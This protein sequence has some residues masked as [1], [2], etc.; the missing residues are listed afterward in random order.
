MSYEGTITTGIPQG[1]VLGPLLFNIFINDLPLSITSTDVTCDL[2]ADDCSLITAAT[3]MNCINIKLQDSLTEILAWCTD[4]QMVL[5]PEKTKCMVVTTRQKHQLKKLLL[6]L[7][8]NNHTIEQVTEHRHL[9]VIIDDRLS[10]EKHINTL[11]KSV[12]KNVYLLSRLSHVTSYEACFFFFHAHV[13]SL[14]N[15]SSNLWDNCDDVHLIKLHSIHKRA[16]KLISKIS[17]NSSDQYN[18]RQPLSLTNHLKFNKCVLVHKLVHGKCPSYLE[19]MV[20]STQR[21]DVSSR[22][23]TFILPRPR[24]DLYKS[25]LNYSG[26]FVW[27]SLPNNL[28]GPSSTKTFKDKLLL[29]LHSLDP[30]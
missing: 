15:Y 22:H 7:V 19:Q 27:N 9:G 2:F 20:E 28:K 14:V 8:L 30:T 16:L 11:S 13:M 25:S 29:Y 5:N 23:M 10:W 17:S 4:N 26:P 18:F 24:I 3:D 1:S 6:N 21:C 12:A